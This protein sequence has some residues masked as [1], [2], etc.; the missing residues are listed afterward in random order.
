MRT[1]E[2]FLLIDMRKLRGQS[3][4]ELLIAFAVISIGLVAA[5]TL[6][7]SNLA[8]VDRDSDEVVAINLA[9]EGAELMKSMRDAN[10]LAG[11][12]FNAGFSQ[13]TDYVGT[14]VWDGVLATPYVDFSEADNFTN[15]NAVVVRSSNPSAIDFMANTDSITGITGTSTGFLRLLTL[16]PI[17]ADQ[18]VLLNG[19]S[20]APLTVSGIRVESRVQW[21]RKGTQKETVIYEDLYDWR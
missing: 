2:E 7:Y 18:S 4:M 6:I 16:H 10:W 15:P 13:G 14:P 20:C 21:V 9:R 8:L 12:A 19:A 1:P 17:C 11:N 5:V 3:I